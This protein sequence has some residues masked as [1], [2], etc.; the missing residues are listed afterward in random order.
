LCRPRLKIIRG[1]SYFDVR[2]LFLVRTTE[3]IASQFVFPAVLATHMAVQSR[4]LAFDPIRN[5]S[6]PPFL[7]TECLG[8]TVRQ[9]SP[10][11]G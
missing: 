4:E 2:V 5:A 7:S 3:V 9:F 1:V 8:A 6:G 11:A 10:Q